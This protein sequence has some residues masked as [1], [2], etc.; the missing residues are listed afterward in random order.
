MNTIVQWQVDVYSSTQYRNAIIDTARLKMD[1][2]IYSCIIF[3]IA[4]VITERKNELRISL[5]NQLI[6]VKFNI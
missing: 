5:N 6:Y 1:Y 2:W 3:D 4:Y